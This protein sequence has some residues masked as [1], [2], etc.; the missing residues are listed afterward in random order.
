MFTKSIGLSIAH[1]NIRGLINKVDDI[2][3]LINKYNIKIFHISETFLNSSVDNKLLCINN[4]N[5]LRKDRIDR[6]GGGVLTYIHKS[7]NFTSLIDLDSTLS[8]SITIKI[9]Q[10]CSKP[11][12]TSVI[13]RAPNSPAGWS[14]SFELYVAKSKVICSELIILG[15][16]NINL[17]TPN[18]KWNNILKQQDLVQLVTQNTRV[19]KNSHSLIDHIYTTKPINIHQSGVIEIGVSDHYLI[20]ASR[21]LGN[22]TSE[23]KRRIKMTYF[24]WKN[25]SVKAFQEELNR[26]DWLSIYHLPTVDAMLNSF[27]IKVNTVISHHLK[28]KTRFVKCSTLP[29]WLDNEV[30][31]NMEKRDKLKS[32]KLWSEYKTQRNYTTNLIRKKKKHYIS[33]LVS[34]SKTKQTKKLWQALRNSYAT[35]TIPDK[36]S[37]TGDPKQD[38]GNMFN[39]YFVNIT[40]DLNVNNRS[41]STSFPSLYSHSSNF[42]PTIHTT[43]ILNIMQDIRSNKA[44]GIDGIS[45]KLLHISLPFI[46]FPLTDIINRAILE[47][48]FP[49]LWKTAIVTPL[50]KGGDSNDLSNYR[51]ISVLPILSKIYEKHILIALKTH[52]VKNNTISR[53]QSGFRENHSCITTIHHLYSTWSN[54][55]KSKNI[56]A[57]IFLDFR[58]AF[59]TVNHQILTAKLKSIGI[60]G[61][62]LDTISSYLTERQQCVKI[63]NIY[64]DTRSVTTGV[65]QGSILA[66]TLFQIFINDLLL[67]PL[68]STP[69][70]YADDTSFSISGSDP[71]LLQLKIDRDLALIQQWCEANQMSLNISK[72]HYLL[73]NPPTNFP[74]TISINGSTLV[75]QSKSKLLGFIINDSLTW[76]D[77]IFSISNKISSNLRLLYNIRHLMNFNVARLYYY[78]FIHSYLIYGLHI[79][80][81]TTPSKYTNTLFI[82]QKKALRLVCKDLKVKPPLNTQALL[83]TQFVTQVTGVLPLPKLSQ[84]FTGITAHS[85]LNNVCPEY[86]SNAFPAL[87][88]NHKTRN[89][90]KLP[91]SLNHNKLN[92]NLLISF[93]SLSMDLRSLPKSSFKHKL[94]SYLLTTKPNC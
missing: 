28:V 78:N 35:D 91:S 6:H 30:I 53:F 4:F 25:F 26:T 67:L 46:I 80:Y 90:F 65:P 77:H 27:T 40:R 13:Y 51:P 93:N 88:H 29:P 33:N 49:K 36:L 59:D 41:T 64:S 63:K 52:L 81:P 45:I 18:I 76:L 7:I 87:K 50:H 55:V 14:D 22:K 43:D 66:P 68:S 8:E 48:T 92:S 39:D 84:Y 82:L 12:I 3:Y 15:D 23:P 71:A 42:I 19:Q 61:K 89:K 32:L 54:M 31:S 73:V 1:L 44:T 79:F 75:Q 62:F 56:L 47:S 85:I 60:G 74:L 21:K 57:I 11:F 17:N 9:S 5:I 70:A 69:H 37:H 86:L 94:K 58:K 2:K 20:F 34:E 24:D 10:S 38:L 83:S 16:F 72:S